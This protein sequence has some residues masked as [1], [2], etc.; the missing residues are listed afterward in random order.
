MGFSQGLID[1]LSAHFDTH[2]ERIDKHPQ[3]PLG[4]LGALHAAEQ[5]SAEHHIVPPSGFAQYQ[6]PGQME[7]ASRAHTIALGLL[8]HLPGQF[9]IQR[10]ANFLY[11]AAIAANV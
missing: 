11:L 3:R 5:H 4:A 1:T 10:N 8:P 9:C 2:R 7:Q 6:G